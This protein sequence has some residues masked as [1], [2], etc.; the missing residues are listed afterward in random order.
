MLAPLVKP[1]SVCLVGLAVRLL[2]ILIPLFNRA[3]V[4]LR[5][6]LALSPL[7]STLWPLL[8][9]IGLRHIWLLLSPLLLPALCIIVIR[10]FC[11]CRPAVS[12]WCAVGCWH[13]IARLWPVIIVIVRLSVVKTIAAIIVTVYAHYIAVS[14]VIT[15]CNLSKPACISSVIATVIVA[16]ANPV[17]RVRIT[18]SSCVNH[19]LWACISGASYSWAVNI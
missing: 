9:V 14:L 4:N 7:V 17:I 19:S 10:S 12:V 5:L 16:I 13:I 2:L 8:L 6:V 3:L 15:A 18:V 11:S 1:L